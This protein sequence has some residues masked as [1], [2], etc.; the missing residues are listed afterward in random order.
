MLIGRLNCY[1]SIDET[2]FDF[3]SAGDRGGVVAIIASSMFMEINRTNIFNNTAQF[4]GVISACNSQV[5][6]LDN[7]LFVTVDPLL[8]FC[9]LYEGDIQI[10]N[11]TAPIDPEVFTTEFLTTT[12]QQTTTEPLTTTQ[13]LTTTEYSTTTESVTTTE[14][15]T[16]TTEPPTT[17]QP[18]ITTTQLTTELSGITKVY[19]STSY[20][21]SCKHRTSADNGR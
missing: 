20:F 15:L 11:I 5:T 2:I 9:M 10:Y 16:T 21:Y 13:R 8:P 7:S 19:E 14:P 4:G 18:P 17:T 6:L 12:E 3:N 1:V